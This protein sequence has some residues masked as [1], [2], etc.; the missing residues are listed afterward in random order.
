MFAN[1]AKKSYN[2]TMDEMQK[3]LDF[4]K[5]QNLFNKKQRVGVGVSG[6]ADS[7]FLLYFLAKYKNV[8]GIDELI[9]IHVNH[10]LRGEESDT[11]EKFVK[12]LCT[13]LDIKCEV[14][15]VD[16]QKTANK[17]KIGVEEAARILRYDAFEKIRDKQYLDTICLAHHKNDQAETVLMH[18]FRG[19]GVQG[20]IGM[21]PQNAFYTRPLLALTRQ[22]IESE[23]KMAKIKY[24]I[25]S[26]NVDTNYTRNFIRKEVLNR[27]QKVY[28]GCIDAVCEFSNRMRADE[29]FIAGLLDNYI[30]SE[31]NGCKIASNVASLAS[32][33]RYRVYMLAFKKV[34]AYKDIETKHL[35]MIDDLFRMKSGAEMNFPLCVAAHR[36]YGG[37][38]F[39]KAVDFSEMREVQFAVPQQITIGDVLIETRLVEAKDVHFGDGVHYMDYMKIPENAKWRSRRQNDEF[40]KLGSG[41]KKLNDYLTDKK[42]PK[43][44][45]DKQIVLASKNIVLAVAGLDVGELVKIDNTTDRI[46]EINYRR[47]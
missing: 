43:L 2:I 7:V 21:L 17:Q 41:R 19:A 33:L 27:V 38:I 42:I 25:D 39:S 37:V 1:L 15:S 22:E 20:A 11:D 14:V 32:T 26:T 13:T 45:R 3:V 16:V 24:R 8:L 40:A 31:S 12:D 10:N 44:Y 34:G 9:A 46:A 4:C 5:E 18:I 28:P 35:K 23:L 29:E 36:V 6:G 30:T 47:K